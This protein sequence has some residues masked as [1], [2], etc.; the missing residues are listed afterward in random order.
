MK[1]VTINGARV[2]PLA[3][4]LGVFASIGGFIFGYDIGQISIFLTLPDF[5]K[6]FAECTVPGDASTCEFSNVREGLIVAMLSAGTLVGSL[7]G[8][9]FADWFGR[10]KA[11]SI[12]C[13]FVVVGTVI[14]TASI[15]SWEQFMVGRII[16]GVGVG[17]LSAAVP[18]S[19]YLNLCT[20]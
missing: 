17:A 4:L 12:D 6:R 1:S 19:T 13:L 5:L 11:M 8:A 15:T 3:L 14:Q 10:R 20:S 16:T 7:A 18:V 2:A 9:M